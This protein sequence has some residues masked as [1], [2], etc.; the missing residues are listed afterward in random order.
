M[1]RKSS[2][3]NPP[4]PRSVL[5]P[6]DIAAGLAVATAGGVVFVAGADAGIAEAAGA[7]GPGGGVAAWLCTLL[8]YAGFGSGAVALVWTDLRTHTLPNRTVAAVALWTAG[9]LTLASVSLG[10]WRAVAASWGAAIAA[11]LVGVLG[12]RAS[13]GALGGGDVKLLPAAVFAAV[14]AADTGARALAAALF[15]LLLAT[16]VGL[17]G[18]VARARSRREL[19][20]GPAI[21]GAA[22]G[23]VALAPVLA[24]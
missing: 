23:T 10:D 24:A 3:A 5:G 8:G 7:G 18:I 14:W 1:A 17:T 15:L 2:R 4:T 21:L 12:W 20:A 6:R 16:A 19:P 11:G 9:A 22:L 13:R